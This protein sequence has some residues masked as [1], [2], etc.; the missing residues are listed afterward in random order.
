M[1]E[2]TKKGLV[3]SL[4]EAAKR[5]SF[6]GKVEEVADKRR[7]AFNARVKHAQ[8]LV[9]QREKK[10]AALQAQ[11][12]HA[13]KGAI[14]DAQ[15]LLQLGEHRLKVQVRKR[16]FWR[17]R[18]VWAHARHNHWGSV[19]KHRRDRLR[20]WIMRHQ[21]FQ[22]YMANG[23]PF[24]KLTP[25]AKHGMYLDFRDGN[26]ITSTYEGHPGDGVHADTSYH[27]LQNQP[28]GRAR[29]WDAGAGSRGPM[30]KAQRREASQRGP[31]LI[32]MFGPE[33]ALAY[34]NG[35]RFTLPEGSELETMHDNHKHTCVR[36]GAPT[37]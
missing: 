32:E 33:N 30:V 20:R 28:D 4:K 5:N 7:H 19:I 25:E 12:P 2:E 31:F 13:P 10:V 29:C 15:Q 8:E 17:D 26:Y 6:F 14:E 24:A 3:A 18:Y 1:A 22:P 27:Y 9:D 34:K 35:V 16:E 21:T 11:G 36:D 23:K 37:R